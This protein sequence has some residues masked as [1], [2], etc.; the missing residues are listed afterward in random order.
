ME[1]TLTHNQKISLALKGRKL[2]LDNGRTLCV[3]C[4][5][6]TDTYGIKAKNKIYGK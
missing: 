3:P 4:H 2:S 5:R 1:T 6:T